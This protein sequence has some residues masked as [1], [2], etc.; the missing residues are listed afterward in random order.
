ME[1]D[2]GAGKEILGVLTQGRRA[3]GVSWN[4]GPGQIVT[5]FEVKVTNGS[6]VT[7][8]LSWTG[9]NSSQITATLS[10]SAYAPGNTTPTYSNDHIVTANICNQI[11]LTLKKIE[12]YQA[13]KK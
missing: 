1:I 2:V 13:T 4:G 5:K 3:S 8:S 9:T 7:N 6:T 11:G 10:W 12:S